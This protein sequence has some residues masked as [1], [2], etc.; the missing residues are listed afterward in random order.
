M[1]AP[2]PKSW[3]KSQ[4][5]VEVLLTTSTAQR[6][7]L[8]VTLSEASSSLGYIVE[9]SLDRSVKGEYPLFRRFYALILT[10]RLLK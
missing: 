3:L 5:E 6:V 10:A 2:G 4:G 1:I 9:V 7:R 8:V